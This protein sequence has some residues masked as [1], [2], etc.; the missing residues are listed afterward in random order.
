VN[1]LLQ[2][3]VAFA[4]YPYLQP[5]VGIPLDKRLSGGAH[6]IAV[7]AP[8]GERRL[9][10]V[11]GKLIETLSHKRILELVLDIALS[12]II[13][14][15]FQIASSPLDVAE[16]PTTRTLDPV[17]A[18]ASPADLYTRN[19]IEPSELSFAS[20]L[21]DR[22]WAFSSLQQLVL[23]LSATSVFEACFALT[24][25]KLAPL[26]FRD[27]LS[28]LLHETITRADGVASLCR[29]ILEPCLSNP[30]NQWQYVDRVSTMLSVMPQ[31]SVLPVDVYYRNIGSQRLCF[32]S[33]LM[34]VQPMK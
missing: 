30:T 20:S 15:L 22:T 18:N 8:G 21:D 12:D 1:K 11:V 14:A 10:H 28:S 32:S 29:L 7:K 26:W 4:I 16:T 25:E 5:G 31:R 2:W 19:T 27:C 3:I 33:H 34:T 9:Q 23:R 13:A 6:A 17:P 24:G